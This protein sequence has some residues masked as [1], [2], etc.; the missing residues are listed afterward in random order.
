MLFVENIYIFASFC[1]WP[2]DVNETTDVIQ[3]LNDLKVHKLAQTLSA[4]V[5]T[6]ALV[7]AALVAGKPILL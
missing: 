1:H 7:Y 6:V 3:L 4:V 5:S 2:P